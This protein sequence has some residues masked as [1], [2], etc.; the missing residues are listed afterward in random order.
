MQSRRV[1][2]HSLIT[3][4]YNTPAQLNVT[5]RFDKEGTLMLAKFFTLPSYSL[6]LRLRV[7]RAG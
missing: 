4:R 1:H 3:V 5:N 7:L 6:K 2:C